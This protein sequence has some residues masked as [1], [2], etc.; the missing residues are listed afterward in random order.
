MLN[1]LKTVFFRSGGK[2]FKRKT[3][4]VSS[5]EYYYIR[6]SICFGRN[7]NNCKINHNMPCNRTPPDEL[8]AYARELYKSSDSRFL[9]GIKLDEVHYRMFARF[10]SCVEYL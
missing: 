8:L 5:R 6:Q 9:A 10:V 1:F 2:S 7:C 3:L 4:D